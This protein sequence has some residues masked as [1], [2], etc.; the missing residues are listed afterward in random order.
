MI[1]FSVSGAQIQSLVEEFRSHKWYSATKKE[2][3]KRKKNYIIFHLFKNKND[4][5]KIK[6]LCFRSQKMSVKLIDYTSV[7]T[8]NHCIYGDLIFLPF[9][10]M[11]FTTA[12]SRLI[13]CS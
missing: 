9:R 11:C 5:F 6:M 3:K 7:T 13:S 8:L 4:L 1:G 12:F 2:K 10:M